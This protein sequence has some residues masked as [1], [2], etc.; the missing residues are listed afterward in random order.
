MMIAVDTNIIVRLAVRDD[1]V[2][3]QKVLALLKEHDFYIAKTVQLEIEWV[4]RSRYKQSRQDIADFFTLLL[5]KT[6]IICE[7]EAELINA[8]CWYRL[9]ADFADAMHLASVKDK[10]FYTF[11]SVFCRNA[12]KEGIAPEVNVL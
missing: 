5:Q 10:T 7:L 11:D 9:G 4:L 3:Y 6:K 12:I 8:V 2:H 1:E